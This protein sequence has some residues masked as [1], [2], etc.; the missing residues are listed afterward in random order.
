MPAEFHMF[1]PE[2]VVLL[3]ALVVFVVALFGPGEKASWRAG[4]VV[5]LALVGAS[6]HALGM[7]GEPFFP[8]IYKV[9]AFSQLLKL[10]LSLGVLGVMMLGGGL[11]SFRPS[12]RVDIPIF[13]LIA[14]AGMMILVSATELLTLY[15]ALELSAYGLCVLIGLGPARSSSREAAAKYVIFGAVSSGV[16][17]YGIS[18]L[19]GASGTTYLEPL[20]KSIAAGPSALM[21]AG[22]VLTLAGLM[23]K[24]ALFPFHSWAPD[25]YEGRHGRRS[26]SAH[27]Q[28]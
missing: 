1:L 9:D 8:G 19:F 11:G 27:I 21:T 3:G 15:V 24:L 25:V 23:F 14:T 16:S 13:L 28:L 20:A 5:S 12:S 6:F 7:E 18:L 2:V 22:L 17:L 10:A 26:Q 4:L